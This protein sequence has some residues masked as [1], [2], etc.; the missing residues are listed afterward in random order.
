MQTSI[1]NWLLLM[2]TIFSVNFIFFNSAEAV[3]YKEEVLTIPYD[4][5]WNLEVTLFK[6]I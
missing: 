4:W 6:P 3:A 1:K 5:S 2:V